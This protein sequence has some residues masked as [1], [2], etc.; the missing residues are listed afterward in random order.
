MSILTSIESGFDCLYARQSE[1][2]M[3]LAKFSLSIDERYKVDKLKKEISD[4][5][6]DILALQSEDML[7]SSFYL[8]VNEIE[9]ELYNIL[10]ERKIKLNKLVEYKNKL[11]LLAEDIFQTSYSIDAIERSFHVSVQ[12]EAHFLD[13]KNHIKNKSLCS[14]KILALEFLKEKLELYKNGIVDIILIANKNLLKEELTFEKKQEIFKIFSSISLKSQRVKNHTK[15][16]NEDIQNVDDDIYTLEYL[17]WFEDL[18]LEM[19]KY[20]NLEVDSY[21]LK[22]RD[23]LCS[24]VTNL[25]NVWNMADYIYNRYKNEIDLYLSKVKN[26]ESKVQKNVKRQLS[27]CL[28]YDE[29]AIFQK[30]YE[31]IKNNKKLPEFLNNSEYSE[32]YE[33]LLFGLDIDY[34]EKIDIQKIYE[35]LQDSIEK[36]FEEEKYLEM[37]KYNSEVKSREVASYR[38]YYITLLSKAK[39]QVKSIYIDKLEKKVAETEIKPYTTSIL[40]KKIKLIEEEISLVKEALSYINK[41]YR[42]FSRSNL[43]IY[44]DSIQKRYGLNNLYDNM[45]AKKSNLVYKLMA[46]SKLNE[47]TRYLYEFVNKKEIKEKLQNELI[48]QIFTDE[49]ELKQELI[50]NLE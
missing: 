1:L 47:E 46:K 6:T 26:V 42:D 45:I 13:I 35:T 10:E 20:V 3:L 39:A 2:D 24:N 43:K 27:K 12:S 28:S 18:F 21:Y 40:L 14:K 7:S 16:Y 8:Q 9:Q 5:L 15:V 34:N 36:L 50:N 17:K 38:Q 33:N 25:E 22:I 29:I 11:Y 37:Y 23:T 44:I 32:S 41:N 19:C 30:V 31:E 4:I 48:N 49:E